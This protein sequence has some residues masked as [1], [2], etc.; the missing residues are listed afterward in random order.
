MS[1][2]LGRMTRVSLLVSILV[3]M[4]A[5]VLAVTDPPDCAVN[6]FTGSIE[7]VDSIP[8]G[9]NFNIRHA[10]DPGTGRTKS[11]VLITDGANRDLQP[12]IAIRSSG[13]SW[14]VWWRDAATDA[15]YY[16]HRSPA[17]GVWSAE[18]RV[19][20]AGES[21]RHPEIAHDGGATWIAFEF[22]SGMSTA[23]AVAGS[24]DSPEPFPSRMLLA[25][26]GYK[27]DLDVRVRA[28][29]GLAWVTWVDEG[30]VVGWCRYDKASASWSLP[31]Y[32]PYGIEGPD[33]ARTRIQDKLLP[34]R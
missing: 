4:A 1:G 12:R 14:V 17:S 23:I 31:A 22:D 3:A 9:A 33:G 8:N 28:E 19:S 25:I 29:S 16:R 15:V 18:T 5:V 20:N 34:P 7:S 13:E 10:V 6:P 11:V 26:S 30:N 32:E 24:T 21:S 27:G 2:T